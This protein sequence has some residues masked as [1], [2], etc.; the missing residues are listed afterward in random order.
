MRKLFD[1][2]GV[3]IC[4]YRRLVNSEPI[5]T[6]SACTIMGDMAT[7]RRRSHD[8]RI[9]R[10]G[11]GHECVEICDG[12]GRHPDLGIA[13]SEDLRREFGCDQSSER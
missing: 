9:A 1:I 10:L 13:R 5:Q 8:H 2:D 4:I 3:T 6:G 7:D 12:P 11:K